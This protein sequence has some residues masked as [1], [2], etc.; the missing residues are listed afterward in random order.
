MNYQNVSYM[1]LLKYVKNN[2]YVTNIYSVSVTCQV[3]EKV[4]YIHSS[5]IFFHFSAEDT[6]HTSILFHMLLITFTQNLIS[7]MSHVLLCLKYQSISAV[8]LLGFVSP[9]RAGSLGQ[10]LTI[11]YPFLLCSLPFTHN[12]VKRWCQSLLRWLSYIFFVK[13][14]GKGKQINPHSGLLWWSSG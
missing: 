2:L 14:R 11:S 8:S 13:G 1:Q 9:N 6:F 12:R 5:H 3:V 10:N 7:K 4:N